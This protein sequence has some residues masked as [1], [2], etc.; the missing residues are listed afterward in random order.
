MSLVNI[1][2]SRAQLIVNVRIIQLFG[3]PTAAYWAELTDIISRVA[4]KKREEVAQNNNFIT[5]DRTYIKNRTSISEEEQLSLDKSLERLG[6]LKVHETNPNMVAI[7]LCTMLEIL[8]EDDAKEIKAYKQL[9]KVKKTDS[10]K[11]KKEYAKYQL[12]AAIVEPDME[13]YTAYSN[14][15]D[16]IYEG[17][18]YLTKPMVETFQKTIK[19]FTSNKAVQ[20]KVI[21]LAMIQG[22]KNATWAINSYQKDNGN[23]SVGTFI[24]KSQGETNVE[25]SDSTF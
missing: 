9:A 6:V 10:S 13:I 23:K 19:Q 18:N 4:E 17:G 8:A 11:S 3:L 5:L 12:K 2:S 20:L 16:S 1:M 7:S 25:V 15:I 22:W 14:W 24:N 21:E